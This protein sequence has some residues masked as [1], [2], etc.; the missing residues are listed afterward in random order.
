MEVMQRDELGL[1]LDFLVHIDP[2]PT[3][4]PTWA[5]VCPCFDLPIE[6]RRHRVDLLN[7][8]NGWNVQKT[9][10]LIEVNVL[11]TKNVQVSDRFSHREH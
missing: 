3:A 5:R 8:K 10:L 9:V 7:I 1:L 2:S 4:T 6:F 11:L